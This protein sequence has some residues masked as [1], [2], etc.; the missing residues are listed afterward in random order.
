[1]SR[2]HSSWCHICNA[3]PCVC[4]ASVPT[5]RLT[6]TLLRGDHAQVDVD[7]A[8]ARWKAAE[9]KLRA[10]EALIE[11]LMANQGVRAEQWVAEED[12]EMPCFERGQIQVETLVIQE[13]TAILTPE[14]Q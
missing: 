5:Q 8:V 6:S 2:P 14:A 7:E 10:V 9:A 3:A 12:A 4:R 1:M 13:L 11:K